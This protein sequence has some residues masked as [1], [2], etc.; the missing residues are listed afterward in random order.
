MLVVPPIVAPEEG[1]VI[2]TVGGTVSAMMLTVVV[3]PVLG[4]VIVT[5]PVVLLAFKMMVAE[6]EL[7]TV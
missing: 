2:E 7:M 4:S 1:A 5:V 6:V 3:A